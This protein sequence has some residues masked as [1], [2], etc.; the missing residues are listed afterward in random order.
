MSNNEV[1]ALDIDWTFELGHWAFKSEFYRENADLP[2]FLNLKSYFL[3]QWFPRHL[4]RLL[5]LHDFQNRRRHISEQT[6][7]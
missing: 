4:L 6:T 1:L 2:V 5:Q 3:N 7:G